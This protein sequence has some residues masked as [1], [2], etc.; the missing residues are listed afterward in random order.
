MPITNPALEADRTFGGP[1][2]KGMS[3]PV[4]PKLR[5]PSER[6]GVAGKRCEFGSEEGP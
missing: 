3:L 4:L 5:N 1:F 2:L 6:S